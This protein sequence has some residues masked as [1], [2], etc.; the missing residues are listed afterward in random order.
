MWIIAA[1]R[2]WIAAAVRWV[3][4]A[5]RRAAYAAARLS[6]WAWRW[7]T[8]ATAWGVGMI[9]RLTKAAC[10]R[11]PGWYLLAWFGALVVILV[12]MDLTRTTAPAFV[13]TTQP[14][15]RPPTQ[16]STQP[17]TR[18]TTQPI[19][20]YE[21]AA[22]AYLW[23][24]GDA[25]EWGLTQIAERLH[26]ALLAAAALFWF[27]VKMHLGEDGQP[28]QR[29]QQP[30]PQPQP[31]RRGVHLFW[32]AM[33][34]TTVSMVTGFLGLLSF[35]DLVTRPALSLG[36]DGPL[37]FLAAVQLVTLGVAALLFLL[38]MARTI[39]R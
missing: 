32:N 20:V 39:G 17:S 29:P 36:H 11:A 13:P 12:C 33:L 4:G 22:E 23:D 35:T 8:A 1:I 38:G 7:L 30:Q 26:L 14:T 37:Q 34:A 28:P 3:L 18:P 21:T 2:R 31:P 16:S 10:P 27:V 24:R 5:T 25:I 15:T 6:V 9:G 19:V